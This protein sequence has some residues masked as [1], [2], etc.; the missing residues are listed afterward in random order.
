MPGESS[1]DRA[2]A[3]RGREHTATPGF[4]TEVRWRLRALDL[5]ALS[6]VPALL[7]AGH[8]L[9]AGTRQALALDYTDPTLVT[10]YTSSFVHADWAHLLDNLGT[11]LVVVPAAY[12]L[13]L[14]S[15]R[16]R[17][18]L[19]V[20]ALVVGVAPF[21]VSLA[22]LPFRSFGLALGFSGVAMALY[23]TVSVVFV[24]Y[25]ATRL[26]TAAHFDHAP[27]VFFTQ[28]AVIALV[29]AQA[30]TMGVVV[31]AASLSFAAIYLVS[32]LR[33][34]TET[35]GP[36]FTPAVRRAGYAEVGVFTLVTVGTVLLTGFSVSR[37]GGGD[38]FTALLAH[39]TG[40]ATGFLIAYVG[41][42]AG[43]RARPTPG[44]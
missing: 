42:R 29:V 33:S 36:V 11:Y 15:G 44:L 34:L 20:F 39:L 23:G 21:V 43:G 17:H 5:L 27:L 9:P 22:T 12:L 7:L 31:V 35:T 13:S 10:A 19:L 32:L 2:P 18:F 3:G 14:L 6:V 41:L 25:V 30:T 38:G 28:I 37:G 4:F 8:L 24:G 1:V 40:F 26:T 16:R